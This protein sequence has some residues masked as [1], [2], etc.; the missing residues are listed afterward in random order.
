M[1]VEKR[2]L[3]PLLITAIAAS[4]SSCASNPNANNTASE[5]PTAT[6]EETIAATPSPT[7]TETPTPTA[8]A[9]PTITETP[10]V[11]ATPTP[12]PSV[13]KLREKPSVEPTKKAPSTL[14]YSTIPS[15]T[16][17]PLG[18]T[19]NVTVYTSDTQCQELVPQKT[20]VSVQQPVED[21]VGK[22]LEGRDNGDFSLSG[23]RVNVKNGIA[24]VD[25]RLSPDSKRLLSSLSSCE[26]F[27]LFGS[28]RKTLTSNNQWKIKDVRFTEKGEEIAL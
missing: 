19:V 27:A 10:T 28:M 26:Q 5:T 13:A 2:Y 21:A 23:Y 6:P 18:K 14:A 22:I 9:T 7:P 11:N 16:Q 12:S 4:L 24:T 25:L 15:A 8:T 20:P 17:T 3:V 1:N